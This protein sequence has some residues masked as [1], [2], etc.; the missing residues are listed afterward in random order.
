MKIFSIA[1]VVAVIL[2]TLY[3]LRKKCSSEKYAGQTFGSR[4]GGIAGPAPN[5]PYYGI[6]PE[7]CF[8]C[9]PP[10]LLVG[11]PEDA[12]GMPLEGFEH[13]S[14]SKASHPVGCPFGGPQN[15]PYG[16]GACFGCPYGCA[17]NEY[18]PATTRSVE[19]CCGR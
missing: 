18:L 1:L 19:T 13:P 5:W 12:E 6:P 14:D 17:A 10:S 4:A 11:Y 9:G 3:I 16:Q 2:L 7:Q 8:G 15:C